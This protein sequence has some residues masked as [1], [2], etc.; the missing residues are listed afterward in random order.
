MTTTSHNKIQKQWKISDQ[1]SLDGF[2]DAGSGLP[3]LIRTLLAKRGIKD[4]ESARHHLSKPKKF[5]DPVLMPN[6]SKAVDRLVQSCE[7]NEKV[8]I[9]GDFDVDGVTATTLLT[10]GLTNLGLNPIP[11]IPDRFS[12]GY[13]PNIS[14]IQKLAE[15]EVTLLITADCGTSSVNEID[16]ANRLGME[17]IIIDHHAIPATLPS[18]YAIVNPKLN[19]LYGSEPA[20]VGVAYKVLTALYEVMDVPYD[21]T[22]HQSLVALGTICDLVPLVGENRDLVRVG[23]EAMQITSRPGLLALAEESNL[24]PSEITAETLGWIFGP[25]IN[26]AGRMQHAKIA[27][28]LLLTESILEAQNLALELGEL[29]RQRRHNTEKAVTLLSQ[30]INLADLHE[31][32]IITGDSTISNG[33]V[34][35]I[36]AKLANQYSRPAIVMQIGDHESRGSCRSV[37]GFNIVKLLQ[38]HQDL[39]IKFGGHHGAAGF[40][41]NSQR[42]DELKSRLYEDTKSYFNLDEVKS[43]IEIDERLKLE[44]NHHQTMQWIDLIGPYGIGNKAPVFL[45]EKI[46]IITKSSVGKNK[47]HLQLKLKH[48]NQSWDAIHFNSPYHDLKINEYIDIVFSLEHNNFHKRKKLQLQIIDLKRSEGRQSTII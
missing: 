15:K 3:I 24:D 22:S 12:E 40:T 10:E 5:T 38:R 34:G 17:V 23:L 8:A 4:T 11:Y 13:G 25:K 31:P 46:K 14:A 36:A 41:I 29:N 37:N 43:E 33:I 19:D 27:L 44:S 47:E 35:L 21:H 26:A 30:K 32:L 48:N 18:A 42:I 9:L 20:A 7:I 39:F 2:T 6:L 28:K 45:S 1:P 16:E